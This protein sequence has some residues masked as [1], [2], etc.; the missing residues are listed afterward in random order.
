MEEEDDVE[1]HDL[2]AQPRSG[3][4]NSGNMYKIK[5]K[6]PTFNESISKS[7]P[8]QEEGKF[9]PS[10]AKKDEKAPSSRK[11]NDKQPSNTIKCYNYREE[12]HISSD[13]PRR[14]FVNTTRRDEEVDNYES[15]GEP[16]LCEEEGEEIVCMVKRLLCSTMQPEETQ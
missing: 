1:E 16:E 10:T 12:G 13:Y 7:S 5:A 3:H 14:K 11:N 9:I 8:R 4:A 2:Y 15:E 6:I